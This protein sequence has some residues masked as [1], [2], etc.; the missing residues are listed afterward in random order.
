MSVAFWTA[1]L[2]VGGE[3]TVQPPENFVLVVTLAAIG[4]DASN[5]GNVAVKVETESIEG[6]AIESILCTLNSEKFP[7][8]SLNLVLGYDVA[9]KF[10]LVGAKDAKGTVYLSGYYQPAPD[11]EDD[12]NMAILVSCFPVM[13]CNF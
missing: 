12:G 9:T 8:F 11:D 10:S 3:V 5:K 4:L 1:N 2:K 6:E 7:Q 13:I